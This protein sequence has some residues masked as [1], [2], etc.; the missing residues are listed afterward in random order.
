MALPMQKAEAHG[1]SQLLLHVANI[2]NVHVFCTKIN[3]C[4]MTNINSNK[5]LQ[6]DTFVHNH[7][8]LN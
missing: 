6:N 5:S 1:K 2:Y 7:I 4:C 3:G 8:E